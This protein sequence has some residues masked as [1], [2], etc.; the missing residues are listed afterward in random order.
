MG[1]TARMLLMMSITC[2]RVISGRAATSKSNITLWL[3]MWLVRNLASAN[4]NQ[5]AGSE[6]QKAG[7]FSLL[8]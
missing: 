4:M 5:A 1:L 8:G 3:V 7:R 6:I 2:V